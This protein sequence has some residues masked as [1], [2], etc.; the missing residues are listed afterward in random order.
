[1]KRATVTITGEHNLV[2]EITRTIREHFHVEYE[3]T[4]A[5]DQEPDQYK[6]DIRTKLGLMARKEPA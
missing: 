6:R 3:V 1:M 2:M 4:T 5:Q